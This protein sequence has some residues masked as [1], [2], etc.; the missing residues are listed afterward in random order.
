MKTKDEIIAHLK[1]LNNEQNKAGMARFGINTGKAFGVGIPVLRAIAKNC[2]KNH[3]LASELWNTG[4][5]EARILAS[6]VDDPNEVTEQ[7]MEEWVLQ[8][9]SWDLCDQCCG[10]LFDKTPFAYEKAQQWAHREEEFVRRAA[11][12]L[13]ASLAVHDKKAADKNFISFFKLIEQYA[14][15]DRNFVKK[16]VN[17]ALRQIGKRNI[18]LHHKAVETAEKIKQQPHKSSRWIAADALRELQSEKV[19]Q[20]LALIK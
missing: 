11:F 8:F 2:K 14:H 9:N 17:W 13:M 12:A 7:Q 16:A 3:R 10:N 5:H 4:F 20:K 18:A 19:K 6:F 1:S 15:D